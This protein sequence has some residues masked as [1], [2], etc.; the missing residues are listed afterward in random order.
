MHRPENKIKMKSRLIKGSV[1]NCERDDFQKGLDLCENTMLVWLG[2]KYSVSLWTGIVGLRTGSSDVLLC[3][4]GR[5]QW[6]IFV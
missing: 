6:R 5:E 3:A 4:D 2:R 1:R